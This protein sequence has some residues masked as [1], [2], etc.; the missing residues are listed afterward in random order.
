MIRLSEKIHDG[1]PF[2][3]T[4]AR[5]R[6]LVRDCSGGTI[7]WFAL[8][9][10]IILGMAG[11]GVDVTLWYMDKRILQTASD[12]GA[13]AGAHVLAQG[14]TD[15][16]ARQTVENEV[17]RNDFHVT[18]DDVITVN[19]PPLSGPNAGTVGF[20]E[21]II[22]KQRPLYFAVFVRDQPTFIQARAVSG[23]RSLGDSCVL[24]LDEDMDAAVEVEGTADSDINCG[25]ASNSRSDSAIDIQGTAKLRA[26]PAQAHGDISISGSATLITNSPT[27]P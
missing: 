15:T 10:P 26:D 2:V 7:I 9:V 8:T 18:A 6:A 3:A 14:G 24:A 16:E 21:V 27:Q 25:V 13:I 23:T 20:V 5:L 1:A 11:L 4:V 22:T 19:T 12:S 17:A